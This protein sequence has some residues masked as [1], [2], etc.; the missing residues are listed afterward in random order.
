MHCCE[1]GLQV[2]TTGP[3]VR[4]RAIYGA[5][6]RARTSSR[7]SSHTGQSCVP[8]N[9]SNRKSSLAEDG[10]PSTTRDF[11]KYYNGPSGV[12][13][14]A[15][16]A[17]YRRSEKTLGGQ[18]VFGSGVPSCREG[19]VSSSLRSMVRTAAYRIPCS[20]ISCQYCA[21]HY[22]DWPPNLQRTHAHEKRQCGF[23]QRC[24]LDT[25]F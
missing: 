5:S 19:H 1:G 7:S 17:E 22:G 20:G 6:Q 2:R 4:K 24:C 21:D 16:Y 10:W 11:V 25:R 9:R 14:P 15:A 8:Q 18:S 13:S 3:A 12:P 23:G